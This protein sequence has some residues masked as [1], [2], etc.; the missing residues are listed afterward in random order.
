MGPA[1]QAGFFC[2]GGEPK[3]GFVRDLG[4]LKIE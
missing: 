2:N 4:V 3:S 1:E